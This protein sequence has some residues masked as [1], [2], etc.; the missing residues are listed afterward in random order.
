MH[1]RLWKTDEEKELGTPSLYVCR[2]WRLMVT[3]C[4]RGHMIKTHYQSDGMRDCHGRIFSARGGYDAMA[5]EADIS[6]MYCIYVCVYVCTCV[7]IY[8]YEIL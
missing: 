6:I 8:V 1:L 7:R 5:S 2:L 3:R 4:C